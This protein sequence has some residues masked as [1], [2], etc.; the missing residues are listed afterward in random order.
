M[1]KRRLTMFIVLAMAC[2]AGTAVAIGSAVGQGRDDGSSAGTA[3]ALA[4]EGGETLVLFRDLKGDGQ[5][6]LAVAGIESPDERTLEPLRCDRSYFAGGRGICLARGDGFA[7]GYKAK[8]FGPDMAVRGE[9]DVS[10]IPSRARVAP[11]G[12]Y[13]SVTLFVTG[14]AYAEAGS[15]STETTLIDL[16]RGERIA[17]LEEFTV[18]HGDRQVTAVDRNFWGVTFARNSDLFYA[19]MATGGETYLIRGSVEGR[20]AEVVHENVEC[21]SLSPDGRRIAYK[22]RVDSEHGP[23]RLAVLD[24]ATMRETLLAETRSV[25]DQAEWL[26]DGQVLYGI[27]GAIWTVRSD[28]E[29]KPRRLIAEADSPAAVR[30]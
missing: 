5:G 29:G 26:D 1:S 15:F 21:P 25:D 17:N 8:V 18:L 24:L 9:V 2:V 7:S 4:G 30:H 19:T 22:K 14:H 16:E 27:D 3:Q 23:W 12:R 11:D 10:G 20:T 6:Q 13:G 28:G